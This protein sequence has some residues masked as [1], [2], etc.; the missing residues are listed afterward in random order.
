MDAKTV[1]W[2]GPLK[3]ISLACFET[4][5]ISQAGDNPDFASANSLFT[6]FSLK[7]GQNNRKGETKKP[8]SASFDEKNLKTTEKTQQIL[9]SDF[10]LIS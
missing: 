10:E 1:F 2:Q 8:F 5:N 6:G 3:G 9:T 4:L 7:N